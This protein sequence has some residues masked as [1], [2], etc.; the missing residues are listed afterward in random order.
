MEWERQGVANWFWVG[1]NGPR[2]VR[3]GM[4]IGDAN[5]VVVQIGK[6]G[7]GCGE[8][9]RGVAGS[10]SS[11]SGQLSSWVNIRTDKKNNQHTSAKGAS[12]R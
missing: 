10:K 3:N 6:E 9:A 4:R 1:G 11:Q 7:G 2:K 8:D 5:C 12:L